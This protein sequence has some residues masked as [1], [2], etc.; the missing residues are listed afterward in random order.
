VLDLPLVHL[1]ASN[2]RPSDWVDR[3]GKRRVRKGGGG[4]LSERAESVA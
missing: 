3:R 4:K 2:T 1:S